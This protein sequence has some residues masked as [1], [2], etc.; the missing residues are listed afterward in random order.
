MEKMQ[1]PGGNPH[2]VK[3][4]DLPLPCNLGSPQVP[5]NRKLSFGSHSST[6]YRL[7]SHM[8]WWGHASKGVC[9]WGMKCYT[10][11]LH[12]RQLH[13]K[14][15]IKEVSRQ[16]WSQELTPLLPLSFALLPG[17][18]TSLSSSM[19]FS[20]SLSPL[21]PTP[22]L[23]LSFKLTASSHCLNSCCRHEELKT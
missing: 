4:G 19:F 5:G 11:C 16:M 22:F 6:C 18:L 12:W 15:T 20:P 7:W 3:L 17:P 23:L 2:M 14:G 1:I 9:R 10:L 8:I 13:R 21:P